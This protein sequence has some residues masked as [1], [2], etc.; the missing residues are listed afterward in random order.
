VTSEVLL[1]V[2]LPG[3]CKT[4]YLDELRREGWIAF[5]D[6][7]AG[8]VGDSSAFH[9]SRHFGALLASVCEGRR[10][11]IADIDFCKSEARAEAEDILGV[12]APTAKIRWLFFD[13][14]PQSCEEDIRC[15]RR[16][17]TEEELKKLHE[18]SAS[19]G[20]PEEADVHPVAKA[21]RTLTS[22]A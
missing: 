20:I 18:Y 8:A 10:C 2:G 7:K 17:S 11:V 21:K 6:F 16:N 3:C 9:K 12:A 1:I 5:D 4:T 13:N 19:Y 15:R 14:N 22:G